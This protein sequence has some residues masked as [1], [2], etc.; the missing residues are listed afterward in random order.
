VAI[1]VMVLFPVGA[2]AL[3]FTNVAITDPG[4]VNQAKVTSTGQLQT[5]P[6]GPLTVNFAPGSQQYHY[7]THAEEN[8][9]SCQNVTPAVPAGKALVVTS[10]VVDVAVVTAPPVRMYT[11]IGT[12]AAPCSVH[13]AVDISQGSSAGS[14]AES[15][16][17]A[18]PSGLFV[19][20]GHTVSMQLQGTNAQTYVSVHGYVV[21]SGTCQAAAVGFTDPIGCY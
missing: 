20:A 18:F 8:A 15:K 13:T 12:E 21:S 10:I 6:N 17:I 7:Q 2:W 19:K 4:G 5:H 9:G 14:G 11:W 16:T 3:S 1:V